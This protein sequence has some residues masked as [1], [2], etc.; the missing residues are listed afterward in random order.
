MAINGCLHFCKRYRGRMPLPH[1][2]LISQVISQDILI[3]KNMFRLTYKI[4]E[5][6]LRAKRSNPG[7]FPKDCFVA[8]LLA[9]TVFHNKFLITAL[10]RYIAPI[11]E[12]PMI[13]KINTPP[14]TESTEDAF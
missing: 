4:I 13:L 3:V 10:T 11:F 8:K 7:G 5:M 9:M 6:S 14:V 2:T 1:K 12:S